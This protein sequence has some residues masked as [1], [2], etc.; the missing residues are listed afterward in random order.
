MF[1][2]DEAAREIGLSDVRSPPQ[3]P[4]AA[5]LL[6]SARLLPDGC[7]RHGQLGARKFMMVYSVLEGWELCTACAIRYRLGK[8]AGYRTCDNRA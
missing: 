4:S 3:Q 6:H 8:R 2:K 1:R 5:H 7:L